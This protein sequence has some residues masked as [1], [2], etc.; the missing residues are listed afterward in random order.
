ML[1]ELGLGYGTLRPSGSNCPPPLPVLNPPPLIPAFCFLVA[2]Q[3]NILYYVGGYT[4]LRSTS[5]PTRGGTVLANSY[6]YAANFTT[7]VDLQ[8]NSSAV[9]TSVTRLPDLVPRIS[10]GNFLW[11]ESSLNFFGGAP[12]TQPIFLSNGSF[13]LADR[14]PIGDTLFRH[15]VSNSNGSIWT[16][17]SSWDYAGEQKTPIGKTAKAFDGGSD[18]GKGA[19]WF[20]GGGYWEDPVTIGLKTVGTTLQM[21]EFEDLW[22]IPGNCDPNHVIACKQNTTTSGN[23]TV[24]R[25]YLQGTMVWVD[26]GAQGLLVLFG[27]LFRGIMVCT[28]FFILFLVIKKNPIWSSGKKTVILLG[29]WRHGHHRRY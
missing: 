10:S 21:V 28:C 26:N 19:L 8:Q 18:D 29:S 7:S 16:R 20:Y 12:T 15:D 5:A 4:Y 25:G 13:S 3:Q 2:Q 14:V 17:N 23:S 27:G 24:P 1:D 9:F 22:R 11:R 6:L